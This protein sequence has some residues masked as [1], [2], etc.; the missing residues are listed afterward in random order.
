MIGRKI[1]LDPILI[2]YF[3]LGIKGAAYSTITLQA[4]ALLMGIHI[5][6]K[7]NNGIKITLKELKP[8]FKYIKKIFKLAIPSIIELSAISISEVALISLVS[9]YSAATIAAYGIGIQIFNIIIFISIGLLV[10]TSALVGQAI[11]ECKP[12]KAR[13]IGINATIFGILINLIVTILIFLFTKQILEFFTTDILVVTAGI[14]F[15]QIIAF[16]FILFGIEKTITGAFHGSGNPHIPSIIVVF[17]LWIIQIPV[18]Y[19][20]SRHT[21]LAESGIWWAIVVAGV[22]ASTISIYMF[23]KYPWTEKSMIKEN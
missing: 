22:M 15:L 14:T 1:S 20:L 7:G 17:S 18:A 4:L 2:I 3:E 16:T 21:T 10:A 6:R 11:G 23:N 19:F 5:L 9:V 12:K 8:D 13:L